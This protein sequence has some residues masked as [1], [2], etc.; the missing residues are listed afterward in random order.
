MLHPPTLT[1]TSLR[2]A[3]SW[4]RIENS[5]D[6]QNFELQRLV[7]PFSFSFVSVLSLRTSHTHRGFIATCSD[8]YFRHTHTAQPLILFLPECALDWLAL[9]KVEPGTMYA[10]GMEVN[11]VIM[12]LGPLIE[13]CSFRGYQ[14]GTHLT[15]SSLYIW[16]IIFF[17]FSCVS[18]CRRCSHVGWDSLLCGCMW[19]CVW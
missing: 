11:M 7:L 3:R 16:S 15:C 13:E 17:I 8:R 18:V 2:W 19:T 12:F 5:R 14:S 9:G 6:L 1:N 10:P 4:A